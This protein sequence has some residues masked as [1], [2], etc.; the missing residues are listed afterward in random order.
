MPRAM[1]SMNL[2]TNRRL[3]V[4]IAIASVL[5]IL[6]LPGKLA[7]QVPDPERDQL[8]NGLR[9]LIWSRP[10]DQNVRLKIRIHSGAVFDTAGKAGTMALLGDILFPDATTRDFF[11]EEMG[12]RLEIRTDY[13]EIE[14][15]ALGRS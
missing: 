11:R 15:T 5:F 3:P 8:L 4:K 13:D 14:I 6:L 12:G 2:S 9:V 10:G 7:A 1:N